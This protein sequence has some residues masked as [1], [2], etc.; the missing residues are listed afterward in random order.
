MVIVVETSRV[1]WPV[2]SPVREH[3][4]LLQAFNTYV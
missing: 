1:V 4:S 3:H 2:A